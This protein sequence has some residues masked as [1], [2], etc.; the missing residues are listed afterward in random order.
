ME[1]IF[2]IVKT[3]TTEFHYK[4]D[5]LEPNKEYIEVIVQCPNKKLNRDFELVLSINFIGIYICDRESG[6]IFHN[7]CGDVRCINGNKGYKLY[8]VND[9]YDINDIL[10]VIYSKLKSLDVTNIKKDNVVKIIKENNTINYDRLT[11]SRIHISECLKQDGYLRPVGWFGTVK[12]KKEELLDYYNNGE[13]F[14]EFEEELPEEPEEPDEEGIFYLVEYHFGPK[15]KPSMKIFGVFNSRNEA[16]EVRPDDKRYNSNKKLEYK[17]Y[18]IL[19]EGESLDISF[20][21]IY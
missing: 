11:F 13:F 14:L 7:G 5:K 21:K 17:T 15:V 4:N 19:K 10:D 9:S 18:K 2:E 6:Q 20:E 16:K 1:H 8:I 12:H 3:Y